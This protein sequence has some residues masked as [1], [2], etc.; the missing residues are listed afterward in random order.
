[1]KTLWKCFSLSLA[2]LATACI[3]SLHSLYTES[4]LIYEKTLEGVWV[5]NDAS[6][7]FKKA[8]GKTYD[9]TMIDG[10]KKA[11][12]FAGHLIKLGD[13]HFL[14]LYP[15]DLETGGSNF[16]DMHFVPA[17]TFAWIQYDDSKLQFNFLHVET[18]ADLLEDDPDALPH[19]LIDDNLVLT[20]E[21]EK[22]QAFILKHMHEDDFF[23]ETDPFK[24]QP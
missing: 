19:K 21:T 16:Y 2:L 5:E 11:G 8:S 1:M 15:T 23:A 18:I 13:R 3:P 24:R 22:L 14:D 12:H 20:A 6:W 4:D 9:I 10:E 17:H 7:I